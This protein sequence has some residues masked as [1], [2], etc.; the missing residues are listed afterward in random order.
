MLLKE[1]YYIVMLAV[2]LKQVL[3]GPELLLLH[4]KTEQL[5]SSHS[6]ILMVILVALDIIVLPQKAAHILYMNLV[7]N[8]KGGRIHILPPFLR[9]LI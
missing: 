3:G 2:G 6:S 1:N 8:I 9:R 5:V 4:M 7:F